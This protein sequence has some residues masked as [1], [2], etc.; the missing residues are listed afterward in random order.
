MCEG[1]ERVVEVARPGKV[2][3]WPANLGGRAMVIV[4]MVVVVVVVWW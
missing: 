3:R 1:V 4:V 2:R